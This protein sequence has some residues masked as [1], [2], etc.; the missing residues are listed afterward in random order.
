[1]INQQLVD[2]IRGQ[3][4]KGLDKEII[5]KELLSNG[6]N[7][8][9]IQEGFEALNSATV[10]SSFQDIKSFSTKK[11]FVIIG[12]CILIVTLIL[13]YLS[14]NDLLNLPIFNDSEN[15]YPSITE[16]I[17]T[18][19]NV[20]KKEE[21]S[22][23]GDITKVLDCG[24]SNIIPDIETLNKPYNSTLDCLGKSIL[25]QC[26][27]SKGLFK[28][29]GS[30]EMELHIFKE[31][32]ICYFKLT[33]QQYI[34]CPISSV[35]AID[36]N[37]KNSLVMK[38]PNTKDATLFAI[39]VFNFGSFVVFLE[40]NYDQKLIENRGCSG[41]LI[42][43]LIQEMKNIRTNLTDKNINEITS[44]TR[45]NAEIYF[46]KNYESNIGYKNVCQAL[47]SE[48]NELKKA[49]VK[50]V[51]CYDSKESYAI[52]ASLVKTGFSCADS[53]GFN[54]I[55]TNNIVGPKCQ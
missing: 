34:K 53:F 10:N 46:D 43:N 4:S 21:F 14:K 40:N 25:N 41:E 44:K 32:D 49:N 1:M 11:T 23:T 26:Q 3:L 42:S 47:S 36:L 52:S 9:D 35:R 7:N 38:D 12:T 39:D 55:I 16:E 33:K 37:S 5:N 31:N 17:E 54:D 50:N 28:K 22:E 20:S 48:I 30:P 24:I 29:E 19:E 51:K 6:W 8:K 45:A 2:F 13:I 15:K 18:I 27:E